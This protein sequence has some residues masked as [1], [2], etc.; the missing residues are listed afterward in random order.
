MNRRDFVRNVVGNGLKATALVAASAA[1]QVR[2][3]AQPGLEKLNARFQGVT[4]RLDKL[5]KR[6]NRLL[7]A[8]LVMAAI[9]TGLDISLLL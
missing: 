5:E 9:S 2:E 6:H 1:G 4:K 3:S 8:C 7:K